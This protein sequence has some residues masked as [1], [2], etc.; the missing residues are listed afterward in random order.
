MRRRDSQDVLLERLSVPSLRSKN[1]VARPHWRGAF[2]K[3]RDRAWRPSLQPYWATFGIRANVIVGGANR[4]RVAVEAGFLR[5]RISGAAACLAR[6]R[7]GGDRTGFPFRP[8]RANRRLRAR[9]VVMTLSGWRWLFRAGLRKIIA[10]VQTTRALNHCHSFAR[11]VISEMGTSNHWAA[12]ATIRSNCSSGGVSK[13]SY[14]LSLCA[15]DTTVA[16]ARR[17]YAQADDLPS[18][19]DHS[20]KTRSRASNRQ[21]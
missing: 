15:G 14:R 18:A 17:L 3:R 9:A 16:R 12:R 20:R 19:Q 6:V 13:I 11:R 8:T 21:R 1:S 4:P 7:S 2:Y 10:G 5:P